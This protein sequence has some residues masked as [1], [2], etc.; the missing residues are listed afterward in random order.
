MKQL[1]IHGDDFGLTTAT[2]QGI[3]KAFS[4]GI[5]TSA[6]LLANFPAFEQAVD[7]AKRHPGLDIGIHFNLLDGQPVSSAAAVTTLL[8]KNGS[9]GETPARLIVNI[10]TRK[11]SLG[12]V[13]TELRKQAEK[14]LTAGVSVSHF[15]GH[16]HIH[17][18]PPILKIL[19][20]I[21]RE[22]GISK[23][24]VPLEKANF[25]P[26]QLQNKTL[27]RR[28]VRR[29]LACDCRF[30]VKSMAARHEFTFPDYF[31]GIMDVGK[32]D[33]NILRQIIMAAPD[34]TTEIMCHPS[35]HSTELIALGFFWIKNHNFA[36]ELEA[37]VNPEI[38]EL[39][40]NRNIR[41]TS[42]RELTG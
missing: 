29:M 4:Q 6:S 23:V 41:L 24:R 28:I 26:G 25:Y 16:Q 34:G 19:L 2:N 27:Y 18:F 32:M 11:T 36:A 38:R 22:Y 37:L 31:T 7:L 17:A 10:L 3:I 15:D 20:K 9:F 35:F 21:A 8:T 1:I 14:I 42:Y 33:S 30:L 39:I 12:Q 13:E 40:D 5:L